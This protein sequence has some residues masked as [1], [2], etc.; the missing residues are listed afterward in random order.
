MNQRTEKFDFKNKTGEILSGRLEIP[1]GGIES[2]ALF[3]HCFTCSKNSLAATRI[4]KEL[5]EQGVAVL[6]FDFTG[7]GNSQ[8]D[9]SNTHFSS[10][11]DDLIS[12]YEALSEKFQPPELLIGHSL[13]GAA[14]I[15]VA[16]ELESLHSIV[17]LGA[18]SDLQ[19]VTHLFASS[20]E[21]IKTQGVAEVTL[22]GRKFKIKKEFID[23]IQEQSILDALS[24]LK[25]NALIMH[26]P[27]DEIVSIDHAAKIFKSL[28]H[29][30]SFISLGHA[31]HL[32]SKPVDAQFIAKMI[33]AWV[34]SQNRN[35]PK[36]LQKAP[37]Q[38]ILV[39]S[40]ENH[41]FTQDVSSPDHRLVA[42]EPP[43][44]QG[45]HL[46]MNPYELLLSALG[47]CTSMTLKLY[48]ERKS[49]PLERCEIKLNHEKKHIDDCKSCDSKQ[50]KLDHIEKGIRLFGNLTEEQKQSLLKIADRCPVHQTLQ[51]EVVMKSRLLTD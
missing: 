27:T 33:S 48:A 8:G 46:G 22:A 26:S 23:D 32:I 2:V 50:V 25:K 1:S 21:T 20:L 18:P 4:S 43:S 5:S 36:V 31:D 49:I 28:K 39:Q 11:C 17:T 35:S 15:K 51:S 44:V 7:L 38:G 40:R 12:A 10:N 16:S 14:V 45:D 37:Q 42:D 47:A 3:A 6:R 9:F 41:R 29:P 24:A 13:G 19:H 34:T 30:K